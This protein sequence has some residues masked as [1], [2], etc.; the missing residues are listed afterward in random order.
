MRCETYADRRRPSSG[1]LPLELLWRLHEAAERT[2]SMV[3]RE[4]LLRPCNARMTGLLDAA[5]RQSELTAELL[6]LRLSW[7]TE[8]AA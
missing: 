5:L 1:L 2:R 8:A 6:E 4:V 7:H 3:E